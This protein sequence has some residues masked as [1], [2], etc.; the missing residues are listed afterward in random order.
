[1]SRETDSPSPSPLGGDGDARP[2]APQAEEK[3]TET[4]LTTRARI[5]I[6]GSRP[7]PPIVV[8]EPVNEAAM[9]A[10]TPSPP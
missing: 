9:R 4:T 6:P 8:R 2:G 10:A 3:K 1:M 7:I 5:N